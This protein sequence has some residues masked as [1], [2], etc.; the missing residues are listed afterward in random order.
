MFAFWEVEEEGEE[1][2]AE[3]SSIIS[4]MSLFDLMDQ[5]EPH[6]QLTLREVL[7][8][9]PAAAKYTG[10]C[11]SIAE[12]DSVMA[13]WSCCGFKEFAGYRAPFSSMDQY[14]FELMV[15]QLD[16]AITLERQYRY[17][18]FTTDSQGYARFRRDS[19]YIE[20]IDDENQCIERSS[21]GRHAGHC[22]ESLWA[23]CGNTQNGH[24]NCCESPH[25]T[26]YYKHSLASR[27]QQSRYAQCR[28]TGTC[29]SHWDCEEF[30]P[31]IAATPIHVSG[32]TRAVGQT[33]GAAVN[34]GSCCA[35]STHT[36]YYQADTSTGAGAVGQCLQ[37]GYCPEGWSCIEYLPE[38]YGVI[39]PPSPPVAVSPPPSRTVLCESTCVWD[40]DG[41]CD[42]GG[43]GSEYMACSTGT[44]CTDCGDRL[45]SET[46]VATMAPLDA[47]SS[48]ASAA[49]C[50]NTCRYA[51]DREC[52]DGGPGAEYS[53]L[54]NLGTDCEDCGPRGSP[55]TAITATLSPPSPSPPPPFTAPAAAGCSDTCN[56]SSDGDCDDGGSGAE[57]YECYSGT[58]CGDCGTRPVVRQLSEPTGLRPTSA[59]QPAP[60]DIALAVDWSKPIPRRPVTVFRSDESGTVVRAEHRRELYHNS[61]CPAV[62]STCHPASTK[63]QLADGSAIRID[64]LIVGTR[65]RTQAGLETVTALM[66]AEH[67]KPGEFFRFHTANASMAISKGH[68]LFVNSVERE[69]ASVQA[70]E[71]LTTSCCGPQP[72][73]RIEKTVE[74]GKF[75]LTTDSATYYADGVLASTYVAYVP[76]NVWR[77]AGGLYPRIR[78]ILGV[79]ITPEGTEGSILSIFWLV[80]VFESTGLPHW[81]VGLLW[82]ITMSSTLFAELL[83]TAATQLPATLTALALVTALA[84]R[85]AHK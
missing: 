81:I 49:L 24:N 55:G 44:D 33:C 18:P 35:D 9:G 15:G 62:A 78:Y 2:E 52:D 40:S 64:E 41:D 7:N 37:T 71:M 75:H 19:S 76:L 13:T 11:T 82:P 14:E 84:L 25:A 27:P 65:I 85:A 56:W 68:Y 63:L 20:A 10:D 48:S 21:D 36:C 50:E 43:P 31:A 69:P 80:D 47:V 42:D 57:Y 39:G 61:Y 23:P 12:A 67:G 60:A 29:P 28:P 34:G 83:N 46:V 3:T 59:A 79:P 73:E 17:N 58:D 38:D 26:C 51:S 1:E 6:G 72:I 22:T 66:H 77:V 70:G 45:V 74:A 16:A 54:C 32:C 4:T 30:T 8:F 53:S 5:E